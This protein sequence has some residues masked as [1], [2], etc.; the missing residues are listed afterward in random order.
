MDMIAGVGSEWWHGT[1]RLRGKVLISLVVATSILMVVVAEP[2]FKQKGLSY[3]MT[4]KVESP[5]HVKKGHSG[6]LHVW[7]VSPIFLCYLISY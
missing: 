2:S 4:Q 3:N 1:S 7:P 5:H 6:Y